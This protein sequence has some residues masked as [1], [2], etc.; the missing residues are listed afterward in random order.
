MGAEAVNDRGEETLHG[1]THVE[2]ADGRLVPAC[3]CGWWSSDGSHA[4][5]E[6]H[7]KR[8]TDFWEDPAFAMD[9]DR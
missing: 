2:R 6:R 5:F 9:R 8:W 4:R 7:L 3:I 1:L